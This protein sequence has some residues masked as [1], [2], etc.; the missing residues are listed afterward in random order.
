MNSPAS[1]RPFAAFTSLSTPAVADACMRLGVAFRAADPG[2]APL[3]RGQKLA[4]PV[5]PVRHHGSVDVFLEACERASAG[6]VLVIDN[7]GRTDEGCIGDLTVLEAR[8]AGLAGVVVWGRHRDT[9]EL[10]RIGWPV[11]SY[12]VQPAGPRGMRAAQPERSDVPFCSFAV[13]PGDCVFA[14]SDG[15]IFTSNERLTELMAKA[16]EISR[17]ERKQAALIESGHSLRR[18]LR[19]DEYL[20]KRRNDPSHT[21]RRH[22]RAIG[23]AIEE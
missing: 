3:V 21:F 15:V 16:V 6:D 19:F 22:L 17:I 20:E 10:V 23:G 5:L 13:A 1:G 4:G 2:I 8:G 9:D 14:D 12:G 11:F 7:Q 18:Q